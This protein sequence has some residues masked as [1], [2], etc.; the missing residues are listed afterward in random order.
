M[1]KHDK[2]GEYW[3]VQLKNFHAEMLLEY[4]ML[5]GKKIKSDATPGAPGRTLG[6]NNGETIMEAEYRKLVGKLLW[7]T[8]KDS[9]HC[10]ANAVLSELSSY[11]S[12]PGKEYLDGVSRVIGFLSNNLDRV[13]KIRKPKELRAGHCVR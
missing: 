13:L 5:T 2:Y 4:E 9:P 7:T 3:E 10:C 1:I 8:T 6:A 11:L 12:C